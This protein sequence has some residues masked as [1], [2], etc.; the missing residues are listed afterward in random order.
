MSTPSEL[1]PALIVVGGMITREV[2]LPTLFQLQRAGEIGEISICSRRGRT[3]A[4]LREMYPNQPFR[5]YPDESTD[6]EASFPDGYQQAIDDLPAGGMVL[7][8]TPDHLH[9]PV[10]LYAL[11]HGKHCVVQKPLC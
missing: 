9:T 4:G 3:L 8:A 6:P 10:V 7:V 1:Y 2:V 5:S 11:Q